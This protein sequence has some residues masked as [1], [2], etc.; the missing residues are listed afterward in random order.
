MKLGAAGCIHQSAVTDS[1]H[2]QSTYTPHLQHFQSQV[3]L[4]SGLTYA[5]E[6]FCG[7]S[8]SVKVVGY[9]RRRALSWIF[10]RM[11]DRILNATL[12]NN[13]L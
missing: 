13:L 12:P 3:H 9:F 11:F 4:E 6:L 2:L 7:N 1:M 8:Q 5:V 10:D